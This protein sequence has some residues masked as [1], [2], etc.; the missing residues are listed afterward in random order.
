MPRSPYD[1]KSEEVQVLPPA[2]HSLK[3]Q[4][5]HLRNAVRFL[6]HTMQCNMFPRHPKVGASSLVN[7]GFHRSLVGGI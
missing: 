3:Q 5:T 1:F 4:A 7:L 6:E 2:R